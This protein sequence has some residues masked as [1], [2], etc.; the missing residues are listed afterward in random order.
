MR[1]HFRSLRRGAGFFKAWKCHE[2]TDRGHSGDDRE[3]DSE[4]EGS[5]ESVTSFEEVYREV[6]LNCFRF[7]DFKSFDE[8]DR[9]TLPEYELLM[10]AVRLRQVDMDYRNHLQAFLNFAVKAQKKAGK[11]KSKPVFAKFKR[12]YDYEKAV[13]GVKGRGSKESRFTGI[14]KFL[15]KGE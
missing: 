4:T 11:N 2:E 10:E 12:F 5:R 15:K 6:A 14:G 8:V 13:E 3:R 9:L 7:L 1:R